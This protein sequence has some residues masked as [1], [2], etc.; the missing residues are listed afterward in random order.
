[1]I[2]V[3]FLLMKLSFFTIET[4]IKVLIIVPDWE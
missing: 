3:M 1:M 4:N 2:C